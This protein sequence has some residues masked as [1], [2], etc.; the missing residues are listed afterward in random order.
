LAS[1][2]NPKLLPI[3]ETQS[4]GNRWVLLPF[5]WANPSIVSDGEAQSHCNHKGK[6]AQSQGNQAICTATRIRKVAKCRESNR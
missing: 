2:L 1:A 4:L 5:N 3:A 6:L